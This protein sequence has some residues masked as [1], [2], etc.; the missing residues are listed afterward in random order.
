MIS[1][2]EIL[3]ELRK[4]DV[5]RYQWRYD[6]LEDAFICSE[7]GRGD[8]SIV[9]FADVIKEDAGTLADKIIEHGGFSQNLITEEGDA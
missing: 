4:R 1:T 6:E 8:V 2:D 5:A 9:S 7:R 3:H